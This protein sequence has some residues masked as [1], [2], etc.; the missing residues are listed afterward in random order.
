VWRLPTVLA[1]VMA[2]FLQAPLHAQGPREP[3]EP[4]AAP[5]REPVTSERPEPAQAVAATAP[6]RYAPLGLSQR[7]PY[8]RGKVPVVFIHGMWATPL[9]WEKMI[10]ALEADPALNANY[11]FWTFGYSTG[12]PI[13]YSAWLLRHSLEEARLQFDRDRSDPAFDRMILVGHSMGGLVAKMLIVDSGDRLWCQVS[14]RPADQLLGD[15]DDRKL[16]SQSLLTKPLPEVRRA[17]FIATPHRGS[18]LD[19]GWL[20]SLGARLVRGT[21]PFRSAYQRIIARNDPGFFKPDF[22]SGLP[23]SIEELQ[24]EAPF[25]KSL[26]ALQVSPEVTFHSIIAVRSGVSQVEQTDGLVSYASAHL[27]GASSE[28]LVRAGHFCQGHPEVIREVRRVL[29][30][31]SKP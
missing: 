26:G 17:I 30:M 3:T 10:A 15:P 12:D 18:R 6:F 25:L 20:Q 7:R 13:P 16:L 29:L 21:E 19:Q 24:W 2:I 11:Q 5:H 4:G 27:E 22:R 14:D 9:S 28:A 23:T 31:Q 1:V 8:A